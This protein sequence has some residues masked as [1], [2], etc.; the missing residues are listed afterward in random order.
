M[1]VI[2]RSLWNYMDKVLRER[3]LV[4]LNG[5]RQTGKSTLAGNLPGTTNYLSFDS[6]V[7]LT[8][9]RADPAGFIRSLPADRLNIIDEIQT[10]PELFP[11]LKMAVDEA[12]GQG[13]G[14][15]LYLLTGSA[16]LMALPRLSEALVGRMSVLTLL[17]FSTSEYLQTGRNFIVNLFDDTLEYRRYGAGP[18]LPELMA[19]ASFPEPALHPDMDRIRWFDDYLSTLLQRDV[20]TV[21]DIRNPLRAVTLLSVLAM[22]AGGLLNN[23]L[24]ARE[25]GLDVKTYERYKGA[26]INTFIIFEVPAWSK[27]NRL[28][29]RFTRS[30]KLFF[31]DVNLLT[32]LLRRDMGDIYRNDRITMG[33]LFE[34]FIAS[35]IMK[36]AAPLPDLSV[37][38]FRTSDQK[39]VDFVLERA[40]GGTVGIEVKLSGSP[41]KHDFAGLKVLREAAGDRFRRGVVLYP[42]TELVSFGEELWALPLPYLW[43][44]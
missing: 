38:H 16:N 26:A 15:G 4:Y 30:P 23:S 19:A 6:P 10:A 43:E 14:R 22:R 29:K 27:P 3:P 40:D 1:T 13:R 11:F 36:N 32:Y 8:A 41:D 18:E 21:A 25:S 35:E 31:T 28:A 37:S 7:V 5:P 20:R 33:R 44:N 17:P 42:G 9:A 24:A 39:E 34:N 2:T 12:R